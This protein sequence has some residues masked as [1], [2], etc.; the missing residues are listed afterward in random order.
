MDARSRA[1]PSAS[2][3]ALLDLG[4]LAEYRPRREAHRP[5]HLQTCEIAHRGRDYARPADAL[6]RSCA[7]V[8]R[9]PIV[10]SGL[11]GY[12]GCVTIG[13]FYDR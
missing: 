8:T 2:R 9:A 6:P 7:L 5:R 13:G 10:R 1:C 11:S 3:S 4:L 12:A